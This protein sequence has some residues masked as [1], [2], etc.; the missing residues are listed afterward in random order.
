MRTAKETCDVI[1][2]DIVKAN[3]ACK[4]INIMCK[5]C[6]LFNGDDDCLN[7]EDVLDR[8]KKYLLENKEN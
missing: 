1:V 5:Y 6:P 3:G 4:K 2:N 7:N 8:S